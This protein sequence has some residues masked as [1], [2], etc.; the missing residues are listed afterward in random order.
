MK[1]EHNYNK[2]DIQK[3][4]PKLK[5]TK[6]KPRQDNSLGVLTKKFVRLIRNSP[7]Q[8][9]EINVVVREL[10]V[11]KRRIYDITNV[12]EGISNLFESI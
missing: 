11:Q 6:S 10:D 9:I 12:L 1:T 7:D 4:D 2:M 5:R 8:T 3:A